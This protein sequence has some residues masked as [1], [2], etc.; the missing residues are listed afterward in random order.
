MSFY[1]Q[2]ALMVQS[3]LITED[4]AF[5]IYGFEL[6]KAYDDL[7]FWQNNDPKDDKYWQLFHNLYQRTHAY[8]DKYK[9]QP[10]PVGIFTF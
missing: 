8:L 10:F 3:G 6:M 1:E 4:A 7:G 2:I 5:Y 9:D